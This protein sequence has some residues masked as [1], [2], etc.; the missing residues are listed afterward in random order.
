[1][2]KAA[3]T[4]RIE[5]G[6]DHPAFSGHFPGRPVLPGVALLAEVL[7]AVAADPVLAM[8]VGA[9]PRLGVVKFLSPVAP[10]ASLVLA[11]RLGDAVDWQIDGHDHV[12]ATGKIARAEQL[13]TDSA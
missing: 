8:A 4:C 5:I 7:E 1:M 11:F 2:T 10:G 12:V 3:V 6:A 9:A 13:A